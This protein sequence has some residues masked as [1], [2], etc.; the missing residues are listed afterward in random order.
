MA[1]SL[2][3]QGVCG[4][5][6]KGFF[7]CAKEWF[8]DKD[9]PEYA[10]NTLDEQLIAGTAKIAENTGGLGFPTN[11]SVGPFADFETL[12][13]AEYGLASIVYVKPE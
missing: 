10:I 13:R 3:A 6:K 9:Y 8:E 1:G 12:E 5:C 11:A 4:V 7:L 2:D